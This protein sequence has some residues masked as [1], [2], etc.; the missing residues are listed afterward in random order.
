M[1]KAY[2]F[3]V[4]G[5]RLQDAGLPI[6]NDALEETAAKAYVAIKE[7]A[8][9]SAPLSKTPIDDFIAPFYDQLD[10]VVFPAIDGFD[11]QDDNVGED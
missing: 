11:G 9:E 3:K 7:W 4:L 10:K 8:K 6:L 5:Q 2:D 1:E